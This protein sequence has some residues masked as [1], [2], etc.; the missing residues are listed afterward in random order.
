MNLLNV[1]KITTHLFIT[2]IIYILYIIYNISII[3]MNRHICIT[4]MYHAV[5]MCSQF[6]F[7]VFKF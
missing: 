5:I 2:H 6:I 7:I 1:K 4:Y 3:N